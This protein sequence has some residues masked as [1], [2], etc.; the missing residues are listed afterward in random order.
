MA[1]S[2]DL[3]VPAGEIPHS[4]SVEALIDAGEIALTKI[5]PLH[6]GE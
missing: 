1:L 6:H 2:F 5:F 3:K 4:V